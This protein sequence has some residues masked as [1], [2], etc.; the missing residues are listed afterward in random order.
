[1]HCVSLLTRVHHSNLPNN[2]YLLF[3]DPNPDSPDNKTVLS[4]AMSQSIMVYSAKSTE[5]GLTTLKSLISLRKEKGL[6]GDDSGWTLRVMTNRTRKELKNG[7]EVFNNN[8]GEELIDACFA[9]QGLPKDTTFYIFHGECPM[10]E[11]LAFAQYFPQYL[12]HASDYFKFGIKCDQ[13]K[14]AWWNAYTTTYLAYIPKDIVDN[15]APNSN[16]SIRQCYVNLILNAVVTK[17]KSLPLIDLEVT[18]IRHIYNPTLLKQHRS[19]Y[20]SMFKKF[21]ATQTDVDKTEFP[22]TLLAFHGT[23]ESNLTSFFETG[24]LKKK[25]G[26]LDPG[27]YGKGYYL[28]TYPQYAVHY[29]NIAAQ[30]TERFK[31]MDVESTRKIIGGYCIPGK[32]KK[33]E[34][35]TE[36]GKLKDEN[37]GF[38]SHMIRVK[39]QE[40]RKVED[41]FPTINKDDEDADEIVVFDSRQFLPCF[42]ITLKRTQ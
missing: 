31:L 29:V 18:E 25:I 10:T 39:K 21:N 38:D 8:A 28:T 33:I 15:I 35:M 30:S 6:K 20:F 4:T 12:S 22:Q 42:E 2:S 16:G 27:Y 11:G 40:I 13:S 7:V 23:N 9:L 24:F 37:D 5:E 26:S 34:D 14:W 17:L 32:K 1:M 36:F 19:Y 41:F 3:V